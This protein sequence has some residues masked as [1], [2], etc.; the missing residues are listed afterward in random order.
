ML[1]KGL[2]FLAVGAI[3]YGLFISQGKHKVLLINDMAGAAKRYPIPA[4]ALSIALLGLGGLPP[5]AGF[6]SKWQIFV[7]GFLTQ[8]VWIMALVVFAAL[9]SVI[10]LGYYAPLINVMYRQKPSAQV[11]AGKPMPPAIMVSLV[12]MAGL[13]ILFGFVPGLMDWLTAPAA[14]EFLMMFKS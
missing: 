3:M 10:S 4:L 7:A 2:A 12:V 13:I 11:E 14:R 1:M 9:N 5:L 8:N 6:M